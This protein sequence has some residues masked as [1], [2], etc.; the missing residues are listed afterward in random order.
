MQTRKNADPGQ[1]MSGSVKTKSEYRAEAKEKLAALTEEY[2]SSA[3]AKIAVNVLSME[4]VRK[5]KT[6]L[7][8]FSVGREPGTLA[9]L[10]SLLKDGKKVCL[11]L[12]TDLDENGH[13]IEGTAAEDSMEARRIKSFEDLV[14]GAYGI[15][16]PGAGTETVSP[17]K[18]DVIILPCV[19]CDRECRRLG[20]GAGYYDKYLSLVKEKCVTVALCYEELLADQLPAE[21]HDIP[22]D[23]V[24]TEDAVYRWRP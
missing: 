9:L 16:E 2:V 4:A 3:S 24:V 5:A 14:R 21:E 22:V 7:A 13:R 1:D 8:Y 15:P 6:V 18:I 19:A 10:D 17:E 11:P 23:A 20:H 12:C